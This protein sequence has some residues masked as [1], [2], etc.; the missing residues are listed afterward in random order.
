MSKRI[1]E[2]GFTAVELLITLFIAAVFL[3]AGYQLYVQVMRDAADADKTARVSNIVQERLR[4]QLTTVS[5]QYP[6]GC[7][8]A[9][10]S[11]LNESQ[12]IQGIGTLSLTIVTRCPIAPATGSATDLFQATVTGSYNDG[13]QTRTIQHSSYT[14]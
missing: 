8:A 7:V 3:F 14:N 5:G 12:T 10:A 11:T 6:N 4:E 2:A 9:S 1:F 13:G